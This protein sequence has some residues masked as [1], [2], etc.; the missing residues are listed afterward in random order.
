MNNTMGTGAR[1]KHDG[2][3]E[4]QGN[5]DLPIDYFFLH[6]TRPAASW[7]NR[8]TDEPEP[9]DAGAGFEDLHPPS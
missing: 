6:G 4:N 1:R 2:G 8:Y 3:R 5:H 9:G 7:G